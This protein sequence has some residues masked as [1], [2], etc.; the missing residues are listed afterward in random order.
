M[1]DSRG[2][3]GAAVGR[4][5]PNIMP[6]LRANLQPDKDAEVRSKFFTLLSQLIV[7]ADTTLNSDNRY[8]LLTGASCLPYLYY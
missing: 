8:V 2:D 1:I 7:N 5:L 6:I 4:L 3:A